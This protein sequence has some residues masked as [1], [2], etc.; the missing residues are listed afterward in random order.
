MLEVLSTSIMSMSETFLDAL[1]A[2]DSAFIAGLW[3]A[4]A[5]SV[6]A[7]TADGAMVAANDTCVRYVG[8]DWSG[9]PLK[10]MLTAVSPADAL[11]DMSP[12][13][14]P[15]W[16]Q[17]LIAY[18]RTNMLHLVGSCHQLRADDRLR[19]DGQQPVEMHVEVVEVIAAWQL[20]DA[21]EPVLVF[22]PVE[23][24]EQALDSLEHALEAVSKQALVNI[25]TL[26]LDIYQRSVAL[27]M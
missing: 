13:A 19:A 22:S 6:C 5:L 9:Q 25:T 11:A 16:Q 23:Q 1:S 7:V 15:L 27:A 21:G 17:P 2:T 8:T 3:H 26:A 24:L 10:H 12:V 20:M 18:K 14:L 4:P